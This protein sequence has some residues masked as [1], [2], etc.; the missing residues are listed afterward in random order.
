MYFSI[1]E[2]SE[3]A[4]M[5][6]KSGPLIYHTSITWGRHTACT[7]KKHCS[8]CCT[9]LQLTLKTKFLIFNI[10]ICDY[11]HLVITSMWQIHCHFF[12]YSWLGALE[13]SHWLI[14]KPFSC[15]MRNNFFGQISAQNVT[16][17]KQL[18]DTV[19][20]TETYKSVTLLY[21]N[22]KKFKINLIHHELSWSWLLNCQL[23]YHLLHCEW[24]QM[25]MTRIISACLVFTI[26]TL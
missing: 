25:G 11:C 15:H 5:V 8:G 9:M 24:A 6:L 13:K 17:D 3:E 10:V 1:S 22:T 12:P 7:Y 14:K 2:P 19:Y 26:L 18:E 16:F 20:C 4:G 21:E 23:C